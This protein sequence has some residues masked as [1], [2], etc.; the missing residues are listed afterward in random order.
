MDTSPPRS[1]PN[2]QRFP[3]DRKLADRF[4]DLPAP[5]RWLIVMQAIAAAIACA[6]LGAMPAPRQGLLLAALAALGLAAGAFKIELC[7]R[8]GRIT[9]AFAVTYFALLALG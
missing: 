3:W 2:A 1:T 8:W 6:L 7:A 9:M 4:R 5:L